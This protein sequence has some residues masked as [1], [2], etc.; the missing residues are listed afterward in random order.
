[1]T[2]GHCDLETE[3]AQ[4]ADSVKNNLKGSATNGATPCSLSDACLLSTQTIFSAPAVSKHS[5]SVSLA[6]RVTGRARQRRDGASVTARWC[7]SRWVADL[8]ERA[9]V[10]SALSA[11]CGVSAGGVC[12]LVQMGWGVGG[13]VWRWREGCPAISRLPRSCNIIP[14]VA[15]NNGT[16]ICSL[17][18][19]P[20]TSLDNCQPTVTRIGNLDPLQM[21]Y[22]ACQQQK[23]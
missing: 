10:T 16:H 1:M 5:S 7:R 20:V 22:R 15:R 13:V 2:H 11:E 4:W 14:A 18:T 17:S 6:P 12:V 19:G 23:S 8:R 9:S 3:S 21:P